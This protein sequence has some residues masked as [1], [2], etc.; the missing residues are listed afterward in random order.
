[1][2]RNITDAWLR[3]LKPPKEGRLEVWD[4]TPG[5]VG[6]NLRVTS[7][8]LFSW[9][10]RTR[11]ADG[12][13]TRVALGS[14]PAVGL[15]AARRRARAM[16]GKVEAGA[17]PVADRKA[18]VAQRK[19]RSLLPTVEERM[20][21]WLE[22]KATKAPRTLTEYRRTCVVEIIPAI[23]R[24]PLKE[25][26]RSDWADMIAKVAKRAPSL[27][28]AV[29]RMASS[30][31]GHAEA[32]GWIDVHPLPRKGLKAIAP[33]PGARKRVLDDDE[34]RGALARGGQAGARQGEAVR[35]L[36]DLDGRA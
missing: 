20:M 6:L 17:D 32:H 22:T 5:T 36:V 26:S 35:S 11:T 29:Y 21:Q 8:G 27:G 25:C 15:S 3:T 10:L 18:V 2:Q 16:L 13:K 28:S 31:L 7:A 9:S 4:Q 19:A 23:G 12:K 34:L 30:F 33:P 24:K 1:M 14:F